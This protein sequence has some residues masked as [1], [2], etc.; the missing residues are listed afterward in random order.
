MYS[1]QEVAR[2]AHVTSRTLRHYE[3]VGLVTPVRASNGHRAYDADALVR[4]QRVLL[5]RGLGLGIP[6]IAEVLAGEAD[7]A[8][9][10]ESHLRQLHEE[11]ERLDRRIA[12]VE[13]TL[14][15]VK[16]DE[17]I[18]VEQMFDGFDHT[19]YRDEVTERW[20]AEAY[21]TGDAWWRGKSDAERAAWKTR[22]AALIAEWAAA[23]GSGI[24]PDSD[25]AQAL[26]Q[27]QFEGLSGIPGTPQT[28]DGHP[29]REYLVGLGDMYVADPRFAANYGGAQGAAFV[30]DALRVYAERT[31]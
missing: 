28:A 12:S 1:I 4:L 23:A 10:L 13:R 18:M 29:T 25:A 14:A 2:L 6:A 30:R 16:G 19:Q 7:D 3:Q 21:R 20:G 26:A 8:T 31:L 15:S 27:R 5:L 24:A 22:S 11:K 9:A 17:Q